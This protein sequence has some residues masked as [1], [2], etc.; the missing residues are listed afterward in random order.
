MVAQKGHPTF[1]YVRG[2]GPMLEITRDGAFIDQNAKLEE[3]PMDPWSSPTILLRHPL[4][5]LSDLSWDPGTAD[6]FGA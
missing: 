4:D 5:E 2:W 3:F 6:P 1:E